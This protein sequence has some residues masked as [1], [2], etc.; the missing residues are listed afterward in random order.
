MG[1]LPKG[2]RSERTLE[3]LETIKQ[4]M[5]SNTAPQPEEV[6]WCG[7]IVELAKLLGISYERT[8]Q[9]CLKLVDDGWLVRAGR[10]WMI[11]GDTDKETTQ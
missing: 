7:R 4:E 6:R 10:N 2:H 1:G 11:V 3:M 5:I 8:R 9:L